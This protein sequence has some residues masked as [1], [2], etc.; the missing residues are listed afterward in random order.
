MARRGGREVLKPGRR[1]AAGE[2]ASRERTFTPA[3]TGAKGR[4]GDHQVEAA[5]RRVERPAASQIGAY[6]AHHAEIVERRVARDQCGE[7]RLNFHRDYFARP[8]ERGVDQGDHAASRAQV[9]H[10]PCRTRS[11]EAREQHGFDRE[12]V[13][14]ARLVKAQCP[15]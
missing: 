1:L 6:R 7:R 9:Q 12:T 11:G 2:T 15:A 14:A 3:Q 8:G 4:V 10:A 13:T 5:R